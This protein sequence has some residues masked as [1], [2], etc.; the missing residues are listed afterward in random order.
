MIFGTKA[1]TESRVEQGP[2]AA[3]LALWNETL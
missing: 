1:S 2:Q 3:E